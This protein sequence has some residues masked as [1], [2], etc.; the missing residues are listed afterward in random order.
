[1]ASLGIFTGVNVGG[2]K[3]LL[4]CKKS[5]LL[6]YYEPWHRKRENFIISEAIALKPGKSWAFVGFA[7]ESANHDFERKETSLGVLHADRVSFAVPKVSPEVHTWL[8]NY[9]DEPLIA[10]LIDKNDTA[11]VIGS[12]NFP[13]RMKVRG[14]TG[15]KF[16][17]NNQY[18]IDLIG[19]KPYM[20]QFYLMS[21]VVPPGTPTRKVFDSGYDYGYLR[22]WL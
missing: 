20:D 15:K 10:V 13:L 6:S 9:V 5:E 17:D 14:G 1:M 19:E 11:V 8:Y 7:Y 18:L 16:S 3:A 12:S 4:V 22:T 2:L 21:E